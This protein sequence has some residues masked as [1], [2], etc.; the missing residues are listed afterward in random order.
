[1]KRLMFLL[2]GSTL[3]LF[4]CD[5]ANSSSTASTG[6]TEEMVVEQ[7]A[8]K[9]DPRLIGGEKPAIQIS[10]EEAQ[11]RIR[12]AEQNQ[13]VG[14]W[15]GDFGKN[16]ITLAIT[17]AANGKASGHSICAG[18]YRPVSGTMEDLGNGQYKFALREPGDDKYDGEFVFSVDL[19]A[20]SLSGTWTPFRM[21]G[22]SSRTYTLNKRNLVYRTDVGDYP[23][24]SQRLLTSADVE[25]LLPEELELMRNEIYARHGYSF[26]NKDMRYHFEQQPWYAPIGVD[27]RTQLTET[28]ARNIDL[29]YEYESYF[30]E[31]YDDFGR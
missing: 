26:K 12:K 2:L 6:D 7:A 28:E 23:E 18:N 19:P 15:T 25:N 27:I 3:T 22:N 24:A 21:P 4:S 17:E 8:M 11:E 14:Y 31:Y 13:L 9:R 5:D 1:M 20:S 16:K 10:I 29:I 30:E